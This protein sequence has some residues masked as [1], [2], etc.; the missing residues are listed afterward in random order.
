MSA[1]EPIHVH[2]LLIGGQWF[3]GVLQLETRLMESIPRWTYCGPDEL[4]KPEPVPYSGVRNKF[5]LDLLKVLTLMT[6]QATH[7][8]ISNM[9]SNCKC[10][11]HDMIYYPIKMQYYSEPKSHFLC[12]KNFHSSSWRNSRGLFLYIA[13]A[14]SSISNS[15]KQ[16]LHGAGLEWESKAFRL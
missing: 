10:W 11:W 5:M 12:L 15:W 14:A 13:E 8:S 9:K 4:Q 3:R 16:R 6:S 2:I 1:W 7:K